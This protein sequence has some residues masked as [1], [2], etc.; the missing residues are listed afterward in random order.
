MRG[1]KEQRATRNADTLSCHSD[2]VSAQEQEAVC[3]PKLVARMSALD[4]SA[5]A[6]D[7]D[8]AAADAGGTEAESVEVEEGCCCCW[9]TSF[10]R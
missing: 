6:S 1:M 7:A 8:D 10:R 9:K 3:P 5:A 4:D 2:G